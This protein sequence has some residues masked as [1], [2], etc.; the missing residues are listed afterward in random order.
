[1]MKET[2]TMF[3]FSLIFGDN[4]NLDP[5]KIAPGFEIVEVPVWIQV[6]PLMTN[7]KWEAKKKEIASWKLPP[8]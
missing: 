4:P 6:D 2:K 7:A 1:M 8:I 3:K 5:A